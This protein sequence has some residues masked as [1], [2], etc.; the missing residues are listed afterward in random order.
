MSD[1]NNIITSTEVEQIEEIKEKKDVVTDYPTR[2]FGIAMGLDG[3][4]N[5]ISIEYNVAT[6]KVKDEVKIL[7]TENS[8][9]EAHYRFK[10]A[11]SNAGIRG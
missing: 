11:A 3:R 9:S 10:I 8:I 7:Y 1:E 6:G 2:A 5:V 4:W